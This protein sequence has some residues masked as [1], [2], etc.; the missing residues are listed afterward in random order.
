[1]SPVAAEDVI[2]FLEENPR[3]FIEHPGFLR[4]SGLLDE[5]PASAKVLNLRERLFE[6]L[7]G[8]REDLILLLDETIDLVRRNEQIEQD[9]IALE[10]L[11]FEIPLSAAN[12][13]RIALEIERRFGLDHASFLLCGP[14]LETLRGGEGDGL[15]RLRTAGEGEAPHLPPGE[16]VVLQG[17]LAEGAG[18]LFPGDIR[19]RIRSAAL[20]PLRREGR[21]LGLLLLGSGDPGR[22]G[23]GMG[24]HLLDRLAGRLALGITL[25]E[26][27]GPGAAR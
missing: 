10:N 15:A 23:P 7:K 18:P 6:R 27:I 17:E 11:L 13:S 22:Y 3:F 8:E 19:Q 12:L 5:S 2:R 20:V 9:F 24:T 21:L 1:M 4:A 14:S 25:L 26:H 16:R